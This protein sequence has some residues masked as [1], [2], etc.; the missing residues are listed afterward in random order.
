MTGLPH[1]ESLSQV[2]PICLKFSQ[3]VCF[4][5][6]I[7]FYCVDVSHFFNHLSVEG[8]LGSFHI[9]GIA[10]KAAVNRIEKLSLWDVKTSLVYMVRSRIAGY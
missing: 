1:S 3:Y 7:V 5:S 8:H 2:P 6:S 9:L 10:N 4:N